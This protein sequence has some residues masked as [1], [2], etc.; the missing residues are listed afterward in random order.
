VSVANEL[1]GKEGEPEKQPELRLS[2]SASPLGCRRLEEHPPTTAVRLLSVEETESR[3]D[4][5][6]QCHT[7]QCASRHA[8]DLL[9]RRPDHEPEQQGQ[10]S[11]DGR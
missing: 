2:S 4:E 1:E 8:D 11:R 3:R 7:K 10:R 6:D 5:D 9:R